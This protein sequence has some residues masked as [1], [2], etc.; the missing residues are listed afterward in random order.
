MSALMTLD[1]GLKEEGSRR[2]IRRFRRRRRSAFARY[3]AGESRRT[4]KGRRGTRVDWENTYLDLGRLEAA[5]E[6]VKVE[7]MQ[8]ILM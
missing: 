5:T 8:A 6:P 1:T 3:S 4:R 2:Q 7:A